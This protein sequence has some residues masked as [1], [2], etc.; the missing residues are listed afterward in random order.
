MATMRSAPTGHRHPLHAPVT[1]LPVA[2]FTASLVFDVL[3][4]WG[5]NA[6]LQ[7]AFYNLALGLLAALVAFITGLVDYSRLATGTRASRLG[8]VHGAVNMGATGAFAASLWFRTWF[9]GTDAVPIPAF[10]LSLLAFA[11]LVVG[12][13]LGH[14][15]VYDAGANV[16]TVPPVPEPAAE[17]LAPRATVVP[18]PVVP[19]RPPDEPIR[20]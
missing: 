19:R 4:F 18:P 13:Y 14:Q 10:L 5:G 7:A 2:V 15:L 17:P 11:V 3:S 12:A 9:T 1:D 6:F 8:L 16:A 20:P